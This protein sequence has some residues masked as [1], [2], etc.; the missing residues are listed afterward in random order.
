MISTLILSISLLFAQQEIEEKALLE[1]SKGEALF[2]SVEEFVTTAGR[3]EQ[4]IEEAPV[5]ITVITEEDIRYSGANS[6]PEV[7]RAVAGVDVVTLTAFDSE[8]NV[9]GFSRPWANKLLVLID[10]R[11]VYEDFFGITAWNALP[12][13][14]GDIKKIEII[15]GPGSVL[16]GANAYSGVVNIITKSPEESK[17]VAALL[18]GGQFNHYIASLIHGGKFGDLGYT[19][20]GGWEQAGRFSEHDEI[21]LKGAKAR[22]QL[23]Y[24][25]SDN[26]SASLDGGVVDNKCEQFIYSPDVLIDNNEGYIKANYNYSNLKAQ[27]F[28][29]ER[30]LRYDVMKAFRFPSFI[31]MEPGWLI[32]DTFDIEAQQL[33]NLGDFGNIMAGLNYRLVTL[34]SNY[35]ISKDINLYAGFLQYE[36][37]P[38]QSLILNA[39]VRLDKQDYMK[40]NTS[41]RGAVIFTPVKNHSFRASISTAFRNPTFIDAYPDITIS[42]PPP[43]AIGITV[44]GNEDLKPERIIS[45]D[46]GYHTTFFQRLKATLDL[47]YYEMS[48]FI[49]PLGSEFGDEIY[50]INSG[51]AKGIGGEIG[52]EY[53]ITSWLKGIFNYSYQW[54]TDENEKQNEAYPV[55]KFNVGARLKVSGLS[56]NILANYVGSIREEYLVSSFPFI[57]RKDL[58]G[59]YVILNAR[60]GYSFLN[61]QMEIA[62]SGQNLLNDTNFKGKL[63]NY[64]TSDPIPLRVFVSIS[65]KF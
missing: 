7:L 35:L 26:S 55:N 15:K 45:Y 10:G 17:G 34:E 46:L 4:R 1:E 43:F 56:A 49:L 42:T 37:K 9:R 40:L 47:F 25:I 27:A 44:T 28:W 30:S 60:V 8:V 58:L 63:Y 31:N 22:G 18:A 41:P 54:I 20:S 24:K 52:S 19:I 36:L 33:F 13:Q 12:I 23:K 59:D 11:S 53:L 51:T 38:I 64:P 39:G 16:Y 62:L 14:L 32:Y 50:S 48:H 65:V 29:R 61:E 6:I 3:M 57:K 5:A 21:S 2:F